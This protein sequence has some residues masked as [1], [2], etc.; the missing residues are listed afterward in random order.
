MGYR[1]KMLVKAYAKV[2]KN[3]RNSA[4][5]TWLPHKDASILKGSFNICLWN[6]FYT[7][8]VWVLHGKEN[9]MFV[10]KKSY[11]LIEG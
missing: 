6:I 4:K 3:H 8:N 1:D 7:G 2:N 10:H 5:K 11:I 9:D